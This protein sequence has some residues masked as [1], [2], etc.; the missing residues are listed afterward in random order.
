MRSSP[1]TIQTAAFKR[2]SKHNQ[3][4]DWNFLILT[5]FTTP[6]TWTTFCC[7]ANRILNPS[8]S[9]RLN[10]GTSTATTS[11]ERQISAERLPTLSLE[12]YLSRQPP[13]Q[14]PL[15]GKPLR[16]SSQ[17][18]LA[19]R[20]G[21]FSSAAIAF[22]DARIF[23]THFLSTSTSAATSSLNNLLLQARKRYCSE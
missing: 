5:T 6:S 21:E 13:Y 12:S 16:S 3:S 7:C 22:F 18:A 4:F 1:G 2:K 10:Q 19:L 9:L 20:L 8:R 17:N 15:A 11:A 23:W 14:S